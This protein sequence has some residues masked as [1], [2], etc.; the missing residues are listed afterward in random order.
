[1]TSASDRMAQTRLAIVEYVQRTRRGG[2][3][4]P[5]K[6][7]ED[8]THGEAAHG[9]WDGVKSALQD[10]WRN[11]PLHMGLEMAQPAV[12]AYAGQ[13]PL[14]LLAL[15]AAAGAALVLARPW[16]LISVTGLLMAAIRSPQLSSAILSALRSGGQPAGESP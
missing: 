3:S 15:S 14:R 10:W 1:M 6:N 11:H 2:S 5:A 13:H 8:N 9:R 12:I 7:D 4:R 16:R